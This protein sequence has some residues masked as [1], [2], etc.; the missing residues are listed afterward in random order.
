MCSKP[1]P[2]RRR[3]WPA[4]TIVTAVFAQACTGV[5]PDAT[6]CKPAAAVAEVAA[7]IYVRQGQSAVVFAGK[8]I[9][10]VGFIVGDRCVA[11]IDTGGSAAEG[12]ALDCAI[13]RIT[14]RPV[15]YVFNTHV[16]PDHMLGNVAFFRPG[17]EFVGHSK[18][19]RA[20]ALRGDVYL[21]RASAYEGRSLE[22]DNIVFPE[23]TVTDAVQFD[24]GGRVLTARAHSSAHTDH[25]LTVI[26]ELT[27][28]TFTG[29]LVFLEHLP[30]IDGSINGWIGE[31]ERLT[32]L[33]VTRVVP[34]H[35]PSSATWPAAAGPAL[36]YLTQLRSD[37]RTWIA[38]GGDLAAAQD[39]ITLR[40][41]ANW[42]LVDEYH[43][44]NIGAAYAELEWED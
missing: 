32:E 37:V 2:R 25:D 7:G 8:N 42:L 44:R 26:D 23:R 33:S 29:D 4:W 16:H 27:D 30:V 34:G 18:L 14:K 22:A 21:A 31:L 1:Q 35:G 6:A 9:A 20:M 5:S 12:R 11:V 15:C 38:K 41:T 3:D 13:Q 43:Q 10:N 24:I 28:T 36:D 17:V 19:P 39:S 40:E